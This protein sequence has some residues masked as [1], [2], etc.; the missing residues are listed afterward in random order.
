MATDVPGT[1]SATPTFSQ[2]KTVLSSRWRHPD[3]HINGLELRAIYLSY[4]WRLRSSAG[5]RKRFLHYVDSLVAMGVCAKGRTSSRRLRHISLKI[6]ALVLAGQLWPVI[7]YCRS[8]RNPSDEASRPNSK[9]IKKI[10]LRP[11]S[12]AKER[13]AQ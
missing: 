9:K 10:V 7:A 11:R 13:S 8:H 5:H 12:P 2:W 3:E 1:S 6:A 4:R